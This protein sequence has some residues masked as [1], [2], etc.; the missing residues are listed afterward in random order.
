MSL[1]RLRLLRNRWDLLS[2]SKL[3]QTSLCMP[4]QSGPGDAVSMLYL[5][6]T[7]PENHRA[8]GAPA[9]TSLA[10][11]LVATNSCAAGRGGPRQGLHVAIEGRLCLCG[12][13]PLVMW[14]SPCFCRVPVWDLLLL[15]LLLA[16][17]CKDAFAAGHQLSCISR[18]RQPVRDGAALLPQEAVGAG[19]PVCLTLHAHYQRPNIC[20]QGIRVPRILLLGTAADAAAAVSSGTAAS[21][22]AAGPCMTAS[23]CWEPA[24][25][26]GIR[27]CCRECAAARHRTDRTQQGSAAAVKCR[28][29]LIMI[30]LPLLLLLLVL[31]VA[32]LWH[33]AVVVAGRLAHMAGRQN[34]LQ[35]QK[36][37]RVVSKGLSHLGCSNP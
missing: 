22:A 21:P 29:H 11:T 33:H 20:N 25:Y 30:I 27:P 35:Q 8:C 1:L 31:W 16:V 37:I 17:S 28:W 9:A 19:H 7:R 32:V 5:V 23:R 4:T 18:V 6:M 26:R 13:W 10:V 15:G 24:G 12:G 14:L 34:Q 3:H 36:G 2:C